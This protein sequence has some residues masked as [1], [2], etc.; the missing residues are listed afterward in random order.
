M[1]LKYLFY[2]IC[3]PIL[4]ASCVNNSPTDANSTSLLPHNPGTYW[5]YE[6]YMLDSNGNIMTNSLI[7]DSTIVA[8][9][10]TIHDTTGTI[11]LTYT[12]GNTGKVDSAFFHSSDQKVYVYSNYF[13]NILSR[14]PFS[15][16]IPL[17][18]QWMKL[19]DENDEDWRL[20][21]QEIPET[22]IINGVTL[23]GTISLYGSKSGIA[24]INAESKN[25]NTKKFTLKMT[26]S[27][28]V[29]YST[30]NIPIN[31]VRNTYLYFTDGVGLIKSV[32]D[33]VKINVFILPPI[34]FPGE[35]QTLIRHYIAN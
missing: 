34:N 5:V 11:F 23:S 33:P 32:S 31:F 16:N 13:T 22:E 28:T 12:I 20:M 8:G 25:F 1:E 4:I 19:V 21:D 26:F 3:L 10:I 35:E 27:G 14:L 30:Y 9:N 7:Y 6:D 17:P 15:L 18:E 24:T 29:K 2:I